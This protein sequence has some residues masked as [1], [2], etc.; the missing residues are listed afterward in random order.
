M[1]VHVD[2][3]SWSL[4]ALD[5]TT[6]TPHKQR[7]I[8]KPAFSSRTPSATRLCFA[9]LLVVAVLFAQWMGLRHRIEHADRTGSQQTISATS[10]ASSSGS[11][12]ESAAEYAGEKLHSCTLFD[13]MALA[14]SAPAL[15]F[16][17]LLQTSVQ[18]LALWAAHAS[19]DA[20]FLCHFSSRAPPAA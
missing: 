9:A 11:T 18:V 4:P 6:H 5:L 20:P 12:L 16:I 13:G 17:P 8:L 14:D 3:Y 7:V 10:A 19:W 1:V 2:P 15:P